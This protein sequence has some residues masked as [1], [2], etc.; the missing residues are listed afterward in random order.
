MARP[1]IRHIALFSRDPVKLSEF[2]RSVFQMDVVHQ[3]KGGAVYMSDGYLTLALLPHE[4]GGEAAVGLNHFGFTVDNTE[5]VSAKLVA[6]GVEQPK[7]RPS[8][9]PFAEHRG[10][11]LD[12]NF[13]D[14]S[15]HG[16]EKIEY[17]ADREKKK[18]LADG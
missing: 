18:A 14:L 15:Q 11:D 10:V 16:F 5:E 9:R 12:G 2:Y 8:N 4:L 7:M 17:R 3:S 13:F 6:A 1:T